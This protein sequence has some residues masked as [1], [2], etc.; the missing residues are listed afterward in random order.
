[1]KT[2]AIPVILLLFMAH[3]HGWGQE[4]AWKKMDTKL[5]A[6]MQSTC[7]EGGKVYLAGVNKMTE[8]DPDSDSITGQWNFSMVPDSMFDATYA[9]NVAV[10]SNTN[11]AICRGNKIY[12]TYNYA[13]PVHNKKTYNMLVVFDLSTKT[14]SEAAPPIFV[15]HDYAM[16]ADSTGILV[17]GGY[18][19]S[20][21]QTRSAE[22]YSF[23]DGAWTEI[24]PLPGT[25]IH[26][27]C[28][29]R[30][31]AFYLL[32]GGPATQ[33]VFEYRGN[34]WSS[35]KRLDIGRAFHAVVGLGD[36]V[37]LIGQIKQESP[38]NMASL[39]IQQWKF[40]AKEGI[41]GTSTSVAAAAVGSNLVAFLTNGEV[42]KYTPSM[43]VSACEFT[44]LPDSVD[45]GASGT[46][47]ALR[48]GGT[49][50]CIL[51][52]MHVASPIFRLAKSILV[53]D[54]S[55]GTVS[56]AELDDASLQEQDVD[57][58]TTYKARYLNIE[59]LT[60]RP[61]KALSLGRFNFGPDTTLP[62]AYDSIVWVEYRFE[63]FFDGKPHRLIYRMNRSENNIFQVER[64]PPRLIG[65]VA[66]DNA[67]ARDGIDED[68]QVLLRFDGPFW[69][70]LETNRMD[71]IFPVSGGHSWLSGFNAVKSAERSPDSTMV[72]V[73]LNVQVSPPTLAVGDTIGY[74]ASN[75]F[76]VLGGSFDPGSAILR[77]L[78]GA[79]GKRI[80]RA[81]Q[82]PDALGRRHPAL[83]R[84]WRAPAPGVG[85][86]N[87]EPGR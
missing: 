19:P 34:A 3:L 59:G 72:L 4:S 5:F 45:V 79:E 63:F 35:D 13:G 28:V 70:P 50:P 58:D 37:Y 76:F 15:R 69:M 30:G 74:A 86:R 27:G 41:P 38:I 44:I 39:D 81:P 36:A 87:Q 48:N 10:G 49:A 84:S 42:W 11:A 47:P 80:D 60:I 17:A 78:P 43:D 16:C 66:L 40:T 22:I 51:D 1:M 46:G 83:G 25:N 52:S 23:A 82:G 65:A 7:S 14:A 6:G 56:R 29:A 73:T 77:R 12:V 24:P 75:S 18:D 55:G 57:G 68:D 8:Y 62:Y 67:E 31:G 26:G 61:G 21:T 71:E 85:A 32:G 54:E 20:E 64:R 9:R 2:T 53:L 33:Q